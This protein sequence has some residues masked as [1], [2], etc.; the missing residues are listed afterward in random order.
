MSFPMSLTAAVGSIAA[1]VLVSSGCRPASESEVES[2][3]SREPV[4]EVESRRLPDAGVVSTQQPI[5]EW[6]GAPHYRTDYLSPVYTIDRI[7]KSMEGPLAME[8]ATLGTPG[9]SE[10]IWI[11]GYRAIL[12]EPDGETVSKPEFM[13]HVNMNVTE[14][15]EVTF[16]SKLPPFANRLFSL[17]QGTQELHFPEGF[18][19]PAQS[20]QPL[21]LNT[22]V[23]NHNIVSDPFDVRMRLQV[24]FI[25]DRE[26]FQPIVPLSLRGAMG[27]VL[28]DGED[29]HYL[30]DRHESHGDDVGPGCSLA[31]DMGHPQ[32]LIPDGMGRTFSGFWRV[33]PGRHEY[34]TRITPFL[35]LPFDTTI[36]A[37]SAHLHPF[38]ESIE[39]VDLTTGESVH[40]LMARTATDK[41][42]LVEVETFASAEGIPL[43]ADHEYD[44]VTVYDNVSGEPQD[45]MAALAMYVHARDIELKSSAPRA[46]AAVSTAE[47]GASH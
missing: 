18:A 23:L 47:G 3:A 11:T 17:D 40:K 2:Q 38:A 16:P 5:G 36:H 46:V 4:E 34:H 45:A 44:L 30:V 24:E 37:M 27:M 35:G 32:G 14:Q 26:L 43:Y 12:V 42:G 19:I 33:E 6:N 41:I 21:L 31:E 39:L 28:V 9:K 8:P 7:Y 1:L 15:Y 20:D 25:R 22:Q 10:L 29:G 13:C